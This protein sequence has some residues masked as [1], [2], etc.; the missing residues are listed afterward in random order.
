M[1]FVLIHICLNMLKIFLK[2]YTQETIN[3]G[4]FMDRN[5]ICEEQGWRD[6]F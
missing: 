3:I 4:F 2:E 5:W 1:V 6:T